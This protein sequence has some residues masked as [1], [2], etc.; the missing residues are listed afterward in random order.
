MF[1]FVDAVCISMFIY[2]RSIVLTLETTNEIMQVYQKYPQLDGQYLQ[3]LLG[4]AWSVCGEL[5]S[6]ENKGN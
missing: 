1:E 5:H 4:V 6:L 3:E 2:L